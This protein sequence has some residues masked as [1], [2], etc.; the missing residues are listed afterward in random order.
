M[1]IAFCGA[2]CTGKT[3][4][5]QALLADKDVTW[6]GYISRQEGVRFL[7]D[8]YNFDMH[9]ATFELQLALL[10]LQT[11]DLLEEHVLLDRTIIDSTTYMMY[12][13]KKKNSNIPDNVIQFI[14]QTSMS[15]V[16]RLDL[17]VF[18]KPEFGLIDDGVRLVDKKQQ[19]DI[20]EGMQ[21]MMEFF[22]VP[23][24]KIIMPT[25]SVE[26][27]VAEVKKRMMI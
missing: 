20:T 23:S 1:R 13:H 22:N 5:I 19:D 27:R 2:Q 26:N 25:G 12:Y 14:L 6:H 15:L 18:L 16:P 24:D 3:T 4:L 8:I 11:R 21:K 7:K 10:A 9:S 17:I